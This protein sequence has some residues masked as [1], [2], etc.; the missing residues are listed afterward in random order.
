MQF[1]FRVK[2]RFPS[3][4]FEDACLLWNDVAGGIREEKHQ[5]DYSSWIMNNV[6]GSNLDSDEKIVAT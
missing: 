2:R 5:T 1:E 4:K 3:F 6:T